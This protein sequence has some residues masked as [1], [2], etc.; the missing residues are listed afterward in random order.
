MSLRC[1][2]EA[3]RQGPAALLTYML[4]WHI[5]H[6]RRT[7]WVELNK[8]N[9]DRAGLTE[10]QRRTG[11]ERL[12]GHTQLLH[13]QQR[14]GRP[15]LVMPVDPWPEE[16][17]FSGYMSWECLKR[18]AAAQPKGASLAVYVVAWCEYSLGSRQDPI[19]LG[20]SQ[21]AKL[22]LKR[23]AWNRAIHKLQK[24]ELLH[25]T[26]QRPGRSPI[27]VPL[28]HWRPYQS[29][30][31]GPTHANADSGHTVR[32]PPVLPLAFATACSSAG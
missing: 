2:L 11:V 10:R 26:A 20:Q 30:A 14:R 6:L 3:A 17:Y 24:A 16:T 5:R 32:P 29:D 18:A 28:D 21:R 8:K 31:A 22:G 9:C 7:E 4:A 19:R 15:T 13:V 25:I 23:S 12:A 27:V 1:L